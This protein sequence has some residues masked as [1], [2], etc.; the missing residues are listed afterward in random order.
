MYSGFRSFF[1][2]LVRENRKF[3]F[4]AL[5]TFV[6]ID[7]NNF[8]GVFFFNIRRLFNDWK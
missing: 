2:I 8:L 4:N 6:V 7:L 5:N 1:R 3:I